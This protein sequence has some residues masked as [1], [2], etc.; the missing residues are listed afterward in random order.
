MEVLYFFF[1]MRLSQ[2]EVFVP[3]QRAGAS[4]TFH[5]SAS[6]WGQSLFSDESDTISTA[7]PHPD[8]QETSAGTSSNTLLCPQLDVFH[9]WERQ[10]T[11]DPSAEHQLLQAA[12]ASANQ[13]AALPCPACSSFQDVTVF[14]G[15]AVSFRVKPASDQDGPWCFSASELS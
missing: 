11:A 8:E 5:S 3:K 6:L 15:I 1:Q 9:S 7:A 2:E 4:F 13:P 14:L 12:W 10:G